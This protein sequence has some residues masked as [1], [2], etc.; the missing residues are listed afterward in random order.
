MVSQEEA[1]QILA[2]AQMYQQ[3]FQNILTQKETLKMQQLEV[4]KAAEEMEKAT[5]QHAYKISGPI[6]IKCSKEEIKK[7]LAEKS[8]L[9]D[10]RLQ[11]LERSE[12]RV[13]EK[14]DEI[15]NKLSKE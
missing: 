12:K 13:K 7:E 6:L 1:Q 14:I 5:E 2:Q 10:T 9:I 11:T 8:E 15:R 3:Q 4:K